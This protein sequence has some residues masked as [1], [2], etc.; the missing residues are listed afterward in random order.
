MWKL[1]CLTRY[2][3]WLHDKAAGASPEKRLLGPASADGGMLCSSRR[4]TNDNSS[5]MQLYA[6]FS[7]WQLPVPDD[8]KTRLLS[9]Q[10]TIPSA[11]NNNATTTADSI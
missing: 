4:S 9:H 8:A 5:C 2:E 3:G 11:I 10:G 1:V 6:T 7:G